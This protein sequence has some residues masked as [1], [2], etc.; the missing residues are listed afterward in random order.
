MIDL[1]EPLFRQNLSLAKIAATIGVSQTT[2]SRQCKK[3]NLSRDSI[4]SIVDNKTI[5]QLTQNNLS[6]YE[7]STKLGIS[8]QAIHERQV[9]LG[10]NRVL[11][12]CTEEIADKVRKHNIDISHFKSMDAIGSYWLGVL[13]ADGSVYGDKNKKPYRVSIGLAI[14]DKQWLHQYSSD[15]GI[16]TS[17][18][19]IEYTNKQ[20]YQSIRVSFSNMHFA[21]L[22]W[23]YGLDPRYK[24]KSSVPSGIIPDHFIR[25]FLDG[26]GTVAMKKG[27]KS[28]KTN[29]RGRSFPAISIYVE[30]PQLA[31]SLKALII[32]QTGIVM[33]GPYKTKSIWVIKSSHQRAKTLGDWIWQ[34]PIRCLERKQLQYL[35]F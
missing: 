34:D 14:K 18:Q 28:K 4:Q 11:S 9:K 35:S 23:R 17:Y 16:S 33:N 30:N 24:Y 3:H 2:V 20:G 13:F 6:I 12:D 15:I 32:F 27:K 21:R 7:M 26:D 5:K 10:I 1:I 25:G 29:V 8:P 22:L 19:M 31:H